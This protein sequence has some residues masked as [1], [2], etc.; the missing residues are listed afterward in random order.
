[1]RHLNLRKNLFVACLCSV[2][3]RLCP[4]EITYVAADPT[5]RD[6]E[7]E[8]RSISKKAGPG[9]GPSLAVSAKLLILLMAHY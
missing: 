8:I 5:W 1:M 3:V 2:V 7:V 9:M 6:F 4:R